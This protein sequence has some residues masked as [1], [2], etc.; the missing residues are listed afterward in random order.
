MIFSSNKIIKLIKRNIEIVISFF[1]TINH[2]RIST[3]FYNNNKILINKNYKNVINN[4]YFQKSINQIFNNLTPRY[5]NIDHKISSGET[6]DK[7]L[8]NYSIPM[9]K[10]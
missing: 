2:Y 1:I 7:I 10:F 3:T 4:I 5:K 9:K 8:N 6:F